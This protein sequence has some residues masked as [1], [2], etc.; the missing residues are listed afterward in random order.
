MMFSRQEFGQAHENR[1]IISV[2]GNV[3]E[4]E[5]SVLLQYPLLHQTF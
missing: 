1:H 5:D 4:L 3:P 2:G